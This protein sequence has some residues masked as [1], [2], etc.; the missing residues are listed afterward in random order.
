M[1]LIE[2]EETYPSQVDLAGYE[3][4]NEDLRR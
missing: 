3:I 1:R 2:N 4:I